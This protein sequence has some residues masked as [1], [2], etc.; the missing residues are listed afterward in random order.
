MATG[1]AVAV[2]RSPHGWCQRATVSW[3][4]STVGDW[5]GF[6]KLDLPGKI[7]SHDAVPLQLVVEGLARDAERLD[8]APDI[9]VVATKC[10]AD[11]LGL[12]AL[13]SFRQRN[14]GVRIARLRG[15]AA[16]DLVQSEHEALGEMGQLADIA[17]PVIFPQMALD[18][19]RRR[20]HRAVEAVGGALHEI[21]EQ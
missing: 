16:A 7:A 6:H 15:R 17:G 5:I 8:R 19:G 20:R 4:A 10:L 21:A 18:G 11:D 3:T 13:Q 14:G 12:V 9:A 1:K 2:T